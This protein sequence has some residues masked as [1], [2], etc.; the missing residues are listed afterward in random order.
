MGG[1]FKFKKFEIKQDKCA[2]KVNT[3]GI[4]LGAWADVNGKSL[5][6]DIGSGTG[7]IG[8]MVAQRNP[9]L[10]THAVEID[11]EAC[12]QASSNMANSPFADRLMCIND[13]IQNFAKSANTKYDL[14]V[15]N[16]PFFSGGTF[17]QNENK[18]SVRHTTKLSHVDLLKSTKSLI[19]DDGHFDLILPYLEGLRFVELAAKYD[20]GLKHITEV[21]SFED[22]PTERVLIRLA[23]KYRNTSTTSELVIYNSSTANDYSQDMIALTKDFYLFM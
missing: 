7:L 11:Q 15:S 14:I 12:Q 18:T 22:K 10:T 19:S 4:L 9:S 21:K 6:L 23:H 3:D 20:F 1:T 2:M 17:S 5:A 13:S 8:L 16:P